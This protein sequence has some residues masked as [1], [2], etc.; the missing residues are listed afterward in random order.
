MAL[1]FEISR[2]D[3]KGGMHVRRVVED[4]IG[5]RENR[6]GDSG[7]YGVI[8]EIFAFYIGVCADV[9]ECADVSSVSSLISGI[10]HD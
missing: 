2:D 1:D 8:V 9:R 10:L 4:D 5:F 6:G 3:G 7:C